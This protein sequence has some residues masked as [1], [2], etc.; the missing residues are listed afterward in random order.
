MALIL[1]L[2]TATEACS[3]ALYDTNSS[4]EAIQ[5]I[6]EVIPREHSQRLLPMIDELLSAQGVKR[7]EIDA[8]AFGRGPGA[9]TGVRIATGVAQGLA[10]ALD[11]PVV[12]VSTLAALAQQ[13]YREQGTTQV[14]A[15]I[16]ARMDEVYWG[17]Y[18]LEGEL[19]TLVGDEQVTAPEKIFSLL[20]ES[21]QQNIGQVTGIG[22]GWCYSDRLTELAVAQITEQAFP[23]AADIAALAGPVFAA[24]QAVP[25]DQALPVYLRDNVALKKSERPAKKQ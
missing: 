18:Q 13:A 5:E 1:S 21:V 19:M 7:S 2:D 14:L 11:V 4:A 24:G 15:L 8:L 22:T 10:W 17:L 9:F 3:A 16:D 6:Y 23:H 12:P 25:A 20:P